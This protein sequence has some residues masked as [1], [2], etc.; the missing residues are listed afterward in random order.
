M[1]TGYPAATATLFALSDGTTSLYLSSGGGVIG[2]HAH[3]S[4][5][6]ASGAFIKAG[7]D[8]LQ[9]LKPC[10]SCPLPAIGQTN[11]YAL[12]DACILTAGAIED[13]LGH[14]RSSLSPLFYAGQEVIT[15][16][17]LISQ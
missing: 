4:V 16:L 6:Q 12:T 2:G 8:F 3:E 14:A 5:R 1:E 10:E 7:N 11:F 17:R 13:D 9:H 15:Q